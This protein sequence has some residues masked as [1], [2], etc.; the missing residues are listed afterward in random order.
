MLRKCPNILNFVE[1]ADIFERNLRQMGGR[2]GIAPRFEIHKFKKKIQNGRH[3]QRSG[4][5]TITR[6]KN[7]Q[8]SVRKLPLI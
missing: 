5:H 2:V 6:Q 7:I 1:A 8:K 3:K 4:Q